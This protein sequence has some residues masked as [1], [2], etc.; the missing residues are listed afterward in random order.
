[1]AKALPTE[2]WVLMADT[3]SICS[4]TGEAVAL[5]ATEMDL[6]KCLTAAA[7]EPAAPEPIYQE[8]IQQPNLQEP[9]FEQEPA[10][11]PSGRRT[12]VV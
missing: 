3:L 8:P 11:Q 7:P 10:S 9:V 12:P 6:L 5:T 4:P 1:M 2:A